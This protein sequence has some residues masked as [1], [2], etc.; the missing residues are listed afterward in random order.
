MNEMRVASMALAA[1]L[2]SSAEAWSMTRI[3]LPGAHE[4]LVELAH[5]RL[6]LRVV[7][8]DDDAV[9]LQ[10]VVDRRAF[11]QELG[12]RDDRERVLREARDRPLAPWP[13]CP[14]GTVDLVTMT[15]KP[16]MARADRLRPRPARSVRSAEPSSSWG[17]PTAMNRISLVRDRRRQVGGEAQ[18]LL[19]HV[20]RDHLVEARLVDRDLARA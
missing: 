15:L 12:V 17:V 8:A 19:G 2:V 6:D 18:P 9:G 10:E 11:L 4:G 3:G 1:Y 14:T 13:P 7:G 16:F 5:D 20:A